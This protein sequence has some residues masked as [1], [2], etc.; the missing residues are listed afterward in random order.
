MKKGKHMAIH[1]ITRDE[2]L[3]LAREVISETYPDIL[4]VTY[5]E[6]HV[7]DRV[8]EKYSDKGWSSDFTLPEERR[9]SEEAVAD[10]IGAQS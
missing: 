1:K 3:T 5:P 2:Y 9:L 4:Y 7:C 6:D 8:W 10:Y